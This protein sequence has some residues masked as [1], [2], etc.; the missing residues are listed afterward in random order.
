MIQC[1]TIPVQ[2]WHTPSTHTHSV[3]LRGGSAKLSVVPSQ[4]ALRVSGL[5]RPQ[6]VSLHRCRLTNYSVLRCSTSCVS[7]MEETPQ[8]LALC[9]VISKG[10]VISY[11]TP[12]QIL[13][14]IFSCTHDGMTWCHG[15]GVCSGQIGVRP[16]SSSLPLFFRLTDSHDIL[17]VLWSQT[18]EERLGMK[19]AWIAKWRSG[20]NNF[21]IRPWCVFSHHVCTFN[22]T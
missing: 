20:R 16:F 4:L 21:S 8:R 3:C 1:P 9:N 5:W 19:W 13:I 2:P 15:V 12:E 22:V 7:E 17:T 14:D 11:L 6:T 10:S 18:E